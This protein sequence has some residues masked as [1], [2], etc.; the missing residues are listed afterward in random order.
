MPVIQFFKNY[1]KIDKDCR[2]KKCFFFFFKWNYYNIIFY[3]KKYIHIYK[4]FIA[5]NNLK[6]MNI[7]KTKILALH[8]VS[9]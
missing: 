1:E 5:E 7:I 4:I 3:K 6:V 9:F 8:F 2:K